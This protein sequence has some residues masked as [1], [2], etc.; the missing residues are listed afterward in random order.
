MEGFGVR[1][2]DFAFRVFWY[3]RY[4]GASQPRV[5]ISTG[6]VKIEAEVFRAEVGVT[7]D[8]RD[9]RLSLVLC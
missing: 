5:A 7:N 2:L 1:F 8:G 3:R 4:T 9:A 6:L